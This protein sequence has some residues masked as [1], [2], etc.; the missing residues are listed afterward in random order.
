MVGAKVNGKIIQLDSPLKNGD[1]VEVITASQTM[2][3]SLDWIKIAKTSQARNKINLWFKKENRSV[4]IEKGKEIIGVDTETFEV[5]NSSLSRD[6]NDFY[7]NGEKLNVDIKTFEYALTGSCIKGEDKNK[8]YE[9]N[10]DVKGW[11]ID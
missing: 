3:P 6:K 1:I 7:Y 10:C 11:V 9:Y 5:L 2:G 8:K 4:N